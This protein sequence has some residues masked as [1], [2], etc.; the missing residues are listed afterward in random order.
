MRCGVGEKSKLRNNH[1]S[2]LMVSFI[3][4]W[5]CTG[6]LIRLFSNNWL[7]LLIVSIKHDT[8]SI[9]NVW[10]IHKIF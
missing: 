8:C 3:R 4:N 1:C 6:W 2:L 7:Q 10:I 5:K 9:A